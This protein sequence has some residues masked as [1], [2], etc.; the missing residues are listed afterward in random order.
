MNSFR[1]HRVV[2]ASLFLPTTAILG[3]S[4]SSTPDQHIREPQTVSVPAVALRLGE[5]PKSRQSS[6][7]GSITGPLKSI[8][9]DLRDRVSIRANQCSR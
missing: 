2:I 5:K 8:V 9:E 6:F 3:E 4:V 1:N 7:T